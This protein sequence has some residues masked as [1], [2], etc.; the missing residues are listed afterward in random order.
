MSP[1]HDPNAPPSKEKPALAVALEYSGEVRKAPT[2]VASGS[3]AVAEQ[4]LQIAFS[5]GIRVRED[6]DLVEILAAIDVGEEIP[7]EA[8][9]AVAEILAYV[10]RANGEAIPGLETKPDC[11]P[12]TEEEDNV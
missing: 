3:G 7:L 8:F 5:Q 12:E 9:A 2:V 1:S 6:A 10:Y 4:I 11:P